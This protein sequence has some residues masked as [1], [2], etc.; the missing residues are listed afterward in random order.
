[1][2]D[3]LIVQIYYCPRRTS[4]FVAMYFGIAGKRWSTILGMKFPTKE[5]CFQL[6][7][8]IFSSA[9][10]SIHPSNYISTYLCIYPSIHLPIHPSIHLYIHL[11]LYSPCE[12]WP[13]F[14]FLNLYTVGRTPWTGEQPVARPLPTHRTTQTQNKSTQTWMLRV[15]SNPQSQ[16]L[17]G[18]RRFMP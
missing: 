15:D 17:R 11:W 3:S 14:Q 7:N 10:H 5:K 13:L 12:P 6:N 18:R 8:E 4:K 2:V 1:M 9:T 16:W